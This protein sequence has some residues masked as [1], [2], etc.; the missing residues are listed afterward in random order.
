M[1]TTT[2]TLKY[3][4]DKAKDFIAGTVDVAFSELQ[5]DFLSRVKPG[6][7]VL[8]FGCG[9]GRDSKAFIKK[10]YKVTAVDGSKELCKYASE[11]IGQEVI[12]STFQEFEPSEQYDGIWAC[13]SLLH[14]DKQDIHSVITKLAEHLI[15]GGC[16]YASFKY[17]SGSLDRNGRFFTDLNEKEFSDLIADIK[18]LKITDEKITSDARPGRENEK[19]LNVFMIKE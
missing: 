13:A 16:F 12:F 5:N 3:Y 6:G 18:A 9:S 8:D 17:G 2:K 1:S 14:L 10:G 4:D 15:T 7:H 11:L 19:W